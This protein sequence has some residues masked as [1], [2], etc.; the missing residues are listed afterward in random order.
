[1]IESLAEHGVRPEDLVPAL[2]T[3][4]TV[5]NPEYDPAEAKRQEAE[6]RNHLPDTPDDDDGDDLTATSSPP[7]PPPLP[8]KHSPSIPATAQAE[9]FQTTARVLEQTAEAAL[10]GVTTTLSAADERVTLD[11]RWT[12][13][14]DLFLILIADS[15]YDARSRVLLEHVALRLGLGWL[16]VAKF[17]RRVTE[18]LEIQEGVEQTEQKEIVEGRKN[19]AKKRRYVM[20]GLA[21]LGAWSFP[22]DLSLWLTQAVYT[23]WWARNRALSGLA[24]ACHWCRPWH[25]PC[26]GWRYR[27][28]D[29]PC[30]CRRRCS[31]YYGWCAHRIQHCCTRHGAP[32]AAREDI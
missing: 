1:M 20:M 18:A 17:E 15:V 9:T 10:P 4:H 8:P 24:R 12:V 22:A 7:P 25:C 6:R 28:D 23:R 5:A 14:C 2:M 29:V 3:T 26:D 27:W 13:L 21:T 30:R 31:H 19:A 11:I 16:D 32:N